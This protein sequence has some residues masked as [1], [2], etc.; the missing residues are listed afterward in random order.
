MT[1]WHL[2]I[3]VSLNTLSDHPPRCPALPVPCAPPRATSFPIRNAP[4]PRPPFAPARAHGY[5]KIPNKSGTSISHVRPQLHSV[6]VF[7]RASRSPCKTR[8]I[9]IPH[10]CCSFSGSS[11][12]R[13]SSEGIYYTISVAMTMSQVSNVGTLSV[14]PL[15]KS[16]TIP[17]ESRPLLQHR[18]LAPENSHKLWNDSSHVRATRYQKLTPYFN[19]AHLPEK[20]DV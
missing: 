7:R 18:P 12:V 13:V 14:R 6:S 8:N 4:A 3:L 17:P 15:S 19:P 9:F 1:R 5:Q 10:F 20:L 11:R 2:S 16:G